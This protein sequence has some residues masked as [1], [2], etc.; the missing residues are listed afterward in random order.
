M[1][2]GASK[3][4]LSAGPKRATLL[5]VGLSG[6]GKKAVCKHIETTPGCFKKN[7]WDGIFT[8]ASENCEKYYAE[9]HAIIFVVDGSTTTGRVEQAAQK[10]KQLV[11]AD[12]MSGKPVLLC[13]SKHDLPNVMAEDTIAEKFNTASLQGPYKIVQ[14]SATVKSPDEGFDWLFD[15]IGQ[16][17]VKLE[18]RISIALARREKQQPAAEVHNDNVASIT[19]QRP[20]TAPSALPA[21]SDTN[22]PVQ[23]TKEMGTAR[24][25]KTQSFD[26]K[27]R[28]L[29]DQGARKKKKKKKRLV[30]ANSLDGKDPFAKK[31]LGAL[32]MEP[33]KPLPASLTLDKPKLDDLLVA[34]TPEKQKKSKKCKKEGEV[35]LPGVIGTPRVSTP[36]LAKKKLPP[37]KRP[38]F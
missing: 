18:E 15:T 1:G 33:L 7:G 20:P 30:R 31:P 35:S 27:N 37:L 5:V 11:T 36:P 6:A 16:Q 4:D 32:G 17:F 8:V 22:T 23:P 3:Q 26:Q 9:A 34:A 24:L 19:E 25:A 38:S 2:C 21:M 14:C 29:S 12:E 10:F 13:V 28:E